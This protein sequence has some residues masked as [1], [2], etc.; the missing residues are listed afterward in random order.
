MCLPRA[1]GPA[2]RGARSRCHG[3]YR[4]PVLGEALCVILGG[5]EGHNR[6]RRSLLL[7]ALFKFRNRPA[8]PAFGALLRER[9]W[10]L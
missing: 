3:A 2:G 8:L 10:Q 4:G 6:S 5:D 9:F 7:Q 1:R